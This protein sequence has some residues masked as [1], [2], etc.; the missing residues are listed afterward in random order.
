ML[1]VLIHVQLI[2][3]ETR[4]FFTPELARRL[5]ILVHWANDA[6]AC[7]SVKNLPV[8]LLKW[9][10]EGYGHEDLS[11]YMCIQEKPV[12]VWIV[13]ELVVPNFVKDGFANRHPGVL[14]RPFLQTDY[15]K[16]VDIIGRYSKPKPSKRDCFLYR[17]IN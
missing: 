3:R 6:T 14:I 5:N 1:P 8:G 9:G 16:C 11:E 13:G 10:K 2:T 15:T 17:D 7:Y 4:E 12:T